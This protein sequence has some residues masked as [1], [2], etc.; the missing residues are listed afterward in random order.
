MNLAAAILR[1]PVRLPY[2]SRP[3]VGQALRLAS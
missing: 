1:Q 2:N 3:I